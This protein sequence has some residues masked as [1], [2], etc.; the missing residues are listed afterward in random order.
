MA[1]GA[2]L[3]RGIGLLA[4]T[5]PAPSHTI[6]PQRLEQAHRKKL[7]RTTSLSPGQVCP[8]TAPS[9]FHH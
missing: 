7:Q 3:Q 4:R 1:S 8:E 6:Q 9:I 5:L 2:E